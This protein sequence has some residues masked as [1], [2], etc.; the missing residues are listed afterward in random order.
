MAYDQVGRQSDNRVFY[1]CGAKAT[2]DFETLFT[3]PI[4]EAQLA[5][6]SKVQGVECLSDLAV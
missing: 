6:Q 1:R 4:K 3:R 5:L 2:A